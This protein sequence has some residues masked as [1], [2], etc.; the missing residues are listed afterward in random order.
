LIAVKSL[1]AEG[2]LGELDV[3]L[4][5]TSLLA[6]RNQ[7]GDADV[8]VKQVLSSA[9]AHPGALVYRVLSSLER[10]RLAAAHRGPQ[11]ALAIVDEARCLLGV[12]QRP[13]LAT[14]IDAV[15]TRWHLEAGLDRTAE[16]LLFT[17]PS[18]HR[19]HGL[20]RARL[21]LV[22]GDADACMARLHELDLPDRR[23]QLERELLRIRAAIA[24]ND[25]MAVA[26][27]EAAVALAAPQG[28]LLTILEEGPLV[29]RLVRA[30]ADQLESPQGLAHALGA[31][32]K[33]RM[34]AHTDLLL[35]DRERNV[36][37]FLPT[38]LTNREIAEECC[39][40]VNTVKTHIKHIYEKLGVSTRAAAE[41][42][43]RTLGLL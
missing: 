22:R 41:D 28:I 11:E 9:E 4:A 33:A 35:S 38:R 42:R 34:P 5:E 26:Y 2:H 29:T 27:G 20:L 14:M 10:V 8:S 36:L 25:P 30:A 16:S 1:G 15:A 43:A 17:L 40:S 7:I 13:V 21:D 3:R 32:P 18:D 24:L 12:R 31:P 6:E 37:R 39:M 19:Q 23:R